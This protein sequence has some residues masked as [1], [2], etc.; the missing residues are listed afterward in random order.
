MAL[1]ESY[2]RISLYA[3]GNLFH[4]F[5]PQTDSSPVVLCGLMLCVINSLN[6]GPNTS[7]RLFLGFESPVAYAFLRHDSDGVIRDIKNNNKKKGKWDS[8]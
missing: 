5:L 2:V 4:R 1:K 7:D 6:R 3:S 8:I